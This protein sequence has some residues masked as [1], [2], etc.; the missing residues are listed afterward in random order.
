MLYVLYNYTVTLGKQ[1]RHVVHGDDC[2][3]SLSQVISQAHLSMM[4]MGMLQTV[5]ML[6]RK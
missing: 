5:T 4:L 3:A 6:L 1:V 2:H